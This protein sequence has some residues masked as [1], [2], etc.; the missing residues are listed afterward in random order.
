MKKLIAVII[1]VFVVPMMTYG[2]MGCKRVEYDNVTKWVQK[3]M[4]DVNCYSYVTNLNLK[5]EVETLSNEYYSDFYNKHHRSE[6]LIKYNN[7]LTEYT[8]EIMKGKKE[9]MN[10]ALDLIKKDLKSPL[11]KYKYDNIEQMEKMITYLEDN[12]NKNI[13]IWYDLQLEIFSIL[14]KLDNLYNKCEIQFENQNSPFLFSNDIC[15]E[16]FNELIKK[17]SELAI[18]EQSLRKIDQIFT[19]SK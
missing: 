11:Y 13:D 12:Y 19:I 2:Q 3:A 14:K 16:T 10:I 5:T 6:V 8:K 17:S 9:K 15:L 7:L 18:K 4:N 1:V